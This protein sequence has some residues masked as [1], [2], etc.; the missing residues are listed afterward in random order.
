MVSQAG[1]MALKGLLPAVHSFACFLST[2]PNEQIYNNAS[3][4]T[5]IMYVGS[6]AGLLPAGPGHSHQSVRDISI[7]AAIPDLVMIEPCSETEV[8]MA[9]DYCVDGATTSSYLRLVSIPAEVPYQLP[10][11]YRLTL[12]RGVTLREGRD[13]AVITYGPVMLSQA[14]KAA[15]TLSRRGLEVAVLN[16][17]WL[18]RVDDA[19]LANIAVRYGWIFTIDNHYVSGGQGQM[20]LAHLAESPVR[21]LPRT[22]RLGITR[23]P[24]CGGNTEV[25]RAHH[26]D[27]E[28]LADEITKAISAHRP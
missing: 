24:Q 9:V 27:G 14:Y 11:D 7:L 22:R 10:P 13:A 4:R 19:W 3:E 8:E 28:S 21:P 5:K 2:R 17:P 18:N 1:G 15:D 12:G 23:I 6:L 16:L 20:L 26:L 25:L